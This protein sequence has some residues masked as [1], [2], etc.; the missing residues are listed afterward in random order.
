MIWDIPGRRHKFSVGY[1][2]IKVNMNFNTL[3]NLYTNVKVFEK[4]FSQMAL[5]LLFASQYLYDKVS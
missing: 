2:K 3:N 1:K 4:V 5:L